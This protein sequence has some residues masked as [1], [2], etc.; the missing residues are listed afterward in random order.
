MASNTEFGF[1]TP[2][3]EQLD[4]FRQKINLP[5]ERW[6]DI[7]KS[8]HDKAFIVAGVANADM[9]QDFRNAID[10]AIAEGK[11]IEEFRKSFKAIVT[12]YGW[13]GWTGEG[14]AAGEAWRT[15]VIYQTN[16]STS[17]AAGRFKQLSDPEYL[18]LRPNWK[19]KHSDSVKHPRP[20]HL[21][22]DGIV[23]PHDHPFW[24]TH[25]GP[26]GWGCECHVVPARGD[27]AIKEPPHGWDKLDPK[28]GAPV[29]I[30]RGFDYAP[31]ES[32]KST[33]KSIIDNKST[34]WPEEIT[35]TLVSSTYNE[36]DD[37]FHVS[38]V[39]K[40]PKAGVSNKAAKVA[41]GVIDSIHKVENLPKIE[42]KNSTSSRFQGAYSYTTMSGKPIDIKIS[43]HSVNPEMTLAHELGHFIDHQAIGLAG[44]Y[45]S[46]S[47]KLFEQWR[48]AVN[49][50]KATD[51][52]KKLAYDSG[53]RYYKKLGE[54][55]LNPV[56]QWARSY[57]QWL[58]YKSNN[59]VM[60]DQVDK[61]LSASNE[62]YAASQWQA[63]DF[64][65]I[66][67]AID[68]IFNTLGWLK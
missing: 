33:F 62:L 7:V 8:A 30:D 67:E 17:Y 3:K 39:L 47:D 50:S 24:L 32:L 42:V 16:M 59:V 4:F 55:Y 15:R 40:L 48:N 36:I 56:E 2:F 49:N 13:T 12:K 64:K 66:A 9:L 37:L 34:L 21:S 20:L 25:F 6:D 31:G 54:Y 1:N 44:R 65:D 29:G 27:E 52:L 58:A 19:Y 26:N 61:I 57:A 5:S 53:N 45:A 22:W 38:D 18:K 11:G 46:K 14:S 28:T 23:L 60:S 43:S 63:D 68:G 41:L 51:K 35:A 10:K